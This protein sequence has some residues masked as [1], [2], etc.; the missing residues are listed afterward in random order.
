MDDLIRQAIAAL[1]AGALTDADALCSRVLE[2]L[3]MH[4]EAIK[5]RVDIAHREERFHDAL[6]IL[7]DASRAEP[8]NVL[9]R[10]GRAR[11]LASLHQNTDA[12]AAYDEAIALCPLDSEFHRGRAF[13]L[14]AGNRLEDALA[15]FDAALTPRPDAVECHVARG[16]TLQRL[17][18]HDEALAA[19]D[20]AIE[21][22]EDCANAWYSKALLLL[23]LGRYAE[24][25]ALHEWRWF[26]PNFP[27]PE[28]LFPQPFW[29]GSPL[30]GRTLLVHAEQGLGDS[31]QFYRF[32]LQARRQGPVALMIPAKLIRLFAS[33]PDAPPVTSESDKLPR[34]EVHCPMGSL[35]FLLGCELE[36]LPNAPYLRADPDLV[37]T[38]RARIPA[39]RFRV[40]I[41][42]AG[43]R[44]QANDHN[45]SMPLQTMLEMLDPRVTVIS[46]QKDVP[47]S[48]RETL[49]AAAHVTDLSDDLTD[50]ADTAAVIDQL[51]LVIT[52]CTSVSH[53]AGAQGAAVWVLL[54]TSADWRWLLDREDSPW[55][56]SARLFRQAK[57][58]DWSGVA[59][60]VREA[61]REM[62]GSA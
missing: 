22:Q 38:W 51:D 33:Q 46:L 60:R 11:V 18:R 28:R 17:H 55:Y 6:A 3:P 21:I 8:D 31:I 24:G 9:W 27:D 41:V 50:F 45:R 62:I 19:Y 40:G 5:L 53:L 59:R 20:R 14:L 57:P 12:I 15:G 1:E 39:G 29:D 43:N 61:L 2:R 4:P 37:G 52:V 30:D 42:W 32:V 13:A 26:T 48:D 47:A 44:A 35:P 56:P 7:D 54:S 58:D 34:F 16:E 23:L 49:R 25:W 36:T 10:I